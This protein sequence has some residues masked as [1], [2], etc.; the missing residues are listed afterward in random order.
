MTG[1]TTTAAPLVEAIGLSV[2]YGA[3]RAVDDVS[4]VIPKGRV[5]GL[6]GHNGAGKTTLMRALVG[7]ARPEGTLRVLGLDPRRERVALLRSACYIPTRCTVPEN[8]RVRASCCAA[9][10]SACR[11][12]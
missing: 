7:L 1:T 11:T 2:R 3:K 5:V 6:L 10:A 12:G 9:P 8:C 4:F